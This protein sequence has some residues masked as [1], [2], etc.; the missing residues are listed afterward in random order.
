MAE[1][2][3]AVKLDIDGG[4]SQKELLTIEETLTKMEKD[5]R[6]I[7][8]SD[9]AAKTAKSFEELNQIVDESAL[10]IQDMTKA[11]DNYINI[12][13]SAGRTSPIGKDALARAGQLKDQI[14]GLRNEAD[15]ASK[16]FQGLQAAMQIGQG[17]IGAYSAFQGTIALLGIENEALMETMVKLQAANSVL[18]GVESVRQVLEKESILVQKLT[19]FWTNVNTKALNIQA[20][21][22][23]K[24]IAVTGIVTAAQWAWNA[25]IAANPVM[26]IVVAI[27]AL[28]AGLAALAIALSDT[29]DEFD[30][31]AV[32]QEAF[33]EAVKEAQLNTVEQKVNLRSLIAVAKDE[34]AS[35]EAR[36]QALKELNKISP[37]Y[38]NNLTLEN[39]ATEE[40]QKLL[41]DYVRAL[42]DKAEAEAVSAKLTELAKQELELKNTTLAENLSW[43]DA[44]AL[45]L[46]YLVDS[47]A[48]VAE[49]EKQA[50]AA[51]EEKIAALQKERKAI[52]DLLKQQEE[53]RLANEAAEEAARKA[54]KEQEDA[55][56]K[57]EQERKKRADE[58]K[59]A[60]EKEQADAKKA[61]EERVQNLIASQEFADALVIEMMKD[62]QEKEEAQR[63]A[64]YEKQIG[65]LEKNGQ[66]TAEIS[67]NLETQLINDLDQIREKH[68]TERLEK[69]K[70]RIQKQNDLRIELMNEGVEKEIE[71]SKLAL[72][73]RLQTL[74]EENLLTQEVKKRLEEQNE[75]ELEEIRKRW[76]EKDTKAT[77]E[78]EKKK[79]EARK[80]SLDNAA[81]AIQGLATIN[82]SITE[83]QLNA[84]GDDEKKKE[85]IRKKS[86][87]REKKLNIAMALING[88]QSIAAAIATGPPQGY[89]F[90][91]INAGIM[92]AQIAAI[93][94][95]KYEGS[96]GSTSVAAPNTSGLN[97]GEQTAETTGNAN[98]DTIT[99]TST[100]LGGQEGEGIPTKVFVSA[101]DISNVQSTTEKIDT[102][103]TVGE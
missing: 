79:Q 48:A 41:D 95:A 69:E 100:L 70:E 75:A 86:F 16:D 94:S 10:S 47:E 74:E 20:K 50:T 1:K 5:L 90:A 102:I 38:F 29:G 66:L 43:T 6:N 85:Q 19:A 17:V 28:V 2:V 3:I 15:Q 49:A 26:L 65:D 97:V 89:V 54:L 92:A 59:K 51:K 14:D 73:V 67:K 87:E 60:R 18:M 83:A 91:A 99:D 45:G 42:N 98:Q 93:A 78:A 23:K 82:N 34:T 63:I 4:K 76:R 81:T 61:E 80:Q 35:L 88:A 36:Q 13:A 8:K 46:D 55:E 12:A 40:G 58:R 53:E 7:S 103:G 11:M 21:A 24:D 56:K 62:G 72:E 25:A 32:K 96:G 39:V 30:E 64:A 84:A 71:A 22:K 44:I 9:A 33:N 68:E 101:V 27:A 37:E 52:E 77:E 31:A 57:A